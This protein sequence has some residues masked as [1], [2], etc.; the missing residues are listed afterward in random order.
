M[1]TQDYIDSNK[2]LTFKKGDH[3][4]MSGCAEAK[5]GKYKNKVWVCQTDSFL[6]K[7]GEEVVFLDGFSGCF[8]TEF[9]I[10]QHI[11]H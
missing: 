11:E 3:V 2:L 10:K 1:T 8:A 7:S 4:V 9:L 5:L 6:L